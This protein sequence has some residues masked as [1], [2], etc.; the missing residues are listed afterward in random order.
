MQKYAPFPAT[1]LQKLH[2]GCSNYRKS[3]KRRRSSPTDGRFVNTR[4][5]GCKLLPTYANNR[6]GRDKQILRRK[7]GKKMVAIEKL[8]LNALQNL[9]VGYKMVHLMH[10]ATIVFILM[11]LS[12]LIVEITILLATFYNHTYTPHVVMIIITVESSTL[13]VATRRL[14]KYSF[15]FAILFCFQFYDCFHSA[16]KIT[17][18][19]RNSQIKLRKLAFFLK[20]IKTE[21]P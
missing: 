10:A 3:T 20:K 14:N 4:K 8:L 18:K 5:A 16:R 21:Y 2:P 13:I 15:F 1:R 17:L 6:R 12:M 9:A 11:M 7:H 19:V